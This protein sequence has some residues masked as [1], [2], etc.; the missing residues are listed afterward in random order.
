MKTS[1]GMPGTSSRGS[2]L[3]Y[4]LRECGSRLS[5]RGTACVEQR[6][7]FGDYCCKLGLELGTSR[8]HMTSILANSGFHVLTVDRVDRGA[9]QNLEGLDVDIQIAEGVEFL[10][11]DTETH[12]VLLVDLHGNSVSDWKRYRRPLMNR[13]KPGG[14]LI[15]NNALLYRIPEWSEEAGVAWFLANLPRGWTFAIDEAV[16]PGVAVV[17]RPLRRGWF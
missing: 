12:S 16:L 14:T 10:R 6:Y 13:L 17:Q 1:T 5:Q 4:P 15:I 3:A 9:R 11:S 7:F 8:G 2:G